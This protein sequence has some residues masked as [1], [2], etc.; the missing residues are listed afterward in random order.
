MI[1]VLKKLERY[2]IFVLGM[3]LVLIVTYEINELEQLSYI[4]DWNTYILSEPIQTE[5]AQDLL[6]EWTDKNLVFWSDIKGIKASEP[7]SERTAVVSLV[8]V[9]GD[10][11][12]LL[13]MMASI[14]LDDTTGCVID[15]ALAEALFGS[16]SVTGQTV[17][18][19]NREYIVRAVIPAPEYTVVIQLPKTGENVVDRLTKQGEDENFLL[20]LG[21]EQQSI[22]FGRTYYELYRIRIF[23]PIILLFLVFAI[24]LGK[25]R[26]RNS[27]YP[28]RW[29]VIFLTQFLLFFGLGLFIL[30][31]LPKDLLPGRW[32]DFQAWQSA[33][34]RWS[35]KLN[36]FKN[37]E[38][39]CQGTFFNQY[40]KSANMLCLTEV[41]SICL[42]VVH[43]RR[44][45][46]RHLIE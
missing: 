6:N 39:T 9:K 46:I 8:Q 34:G 35:D 4:S 13:P 15:T 2:W 31:L 27:D 29:T 24:Y 14:S 28:A 43:S 37:A 11:R 3:L 10:L 42:L 5:Q 40:L 41:I 21:I 12:H 26:R 33:M 1:S 30:Y 20:N 17:Q 38:S 18:I 22:A 16:I 32:S 25:F 7:I 36:I 44:T 23:A 45:I 19:N